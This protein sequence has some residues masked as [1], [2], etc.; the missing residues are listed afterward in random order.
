VLI[1]RHH[2]V[3]NGRFHSSLV[4]VQFLVVC[5]MAADF[6]ST[7]CFTIIV[8][9]G[10]ILLPFLCK[11]RNS[12]LRQKKGETKSVLVCIVV[13]FTT[14]YQLLM[15]ERILHFFVQL[16]HYVKCLHEHRFDL[17]SSPLYGNTITAMRFRYQKV[18]QPS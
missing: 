15:P 14:Y 16:L 6:L 7:L 3:K 8:S 18:L 4:Y 10:N 11:K 12:V 1:I 5:I 9:S 17:A 13:R 2:R